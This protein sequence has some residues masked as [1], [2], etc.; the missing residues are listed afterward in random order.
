MVKFIGPK[1]TWKMSLGLAFDGVIRLALNIRMS[2]ERSTR[3]LKP[4][5]RPAPSVGN[6]IATVWG[7]DVNI[8]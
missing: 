5:L 1:I 3:L 4:S 8:N 6:T 7:P 2:S